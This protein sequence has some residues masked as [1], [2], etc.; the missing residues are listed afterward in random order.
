MVVA[1]D[2]RTVDQG[3]IIHKGGTDNFVL[4]EVGAN[5]GVGVE[6]GSF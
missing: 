2:G 3:S 4:S 6:L 5:T 1:E